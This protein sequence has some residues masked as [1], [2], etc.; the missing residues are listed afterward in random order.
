MLHSIVPAGNFSNG[1][2][3][4]PGPERP[5]NSA[6]RYTVK[7]SCHTNPPTAARVRAQTPEKVLEDNGRKR[8]RRT[9]GHAGFSPELAAGKQ[10]H[11]SN[12]VYVYKLNPVAGSGARRTRPAP[13]PPAAGRTENGGWSFLSADRKWRGSVRSPDLGSG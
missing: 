11:R 1:L 8:R 7:T 6:V 3:N 4:R 5:K 2:L 13:G 9:F 10:L 12:P